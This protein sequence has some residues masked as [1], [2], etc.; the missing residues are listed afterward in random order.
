MVLLRCEYFTLAPR[1]QQAGTIFRT[2]GFIQTRWLYTS[3]FSYRRV[4]TVTSPK[5]RTGVRA[6]VCGGVRRRYV[7]GL[8]RLFVPRTMAVRTSIVHGVRCAALCKALPVRYICVLFCFFAPP[9]GARV[10][11]G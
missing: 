6:V 1:Q 10:L 5:L 7:A 4:P 11:D 3:H 9:E 8:V 2:S